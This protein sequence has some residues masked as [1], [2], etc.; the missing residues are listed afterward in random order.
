[1]RRIAEAL[2]S[3]IVGAVGLEGLLVSGGLAGLTVVAWSAD[4]RYGVLVA[5]AA[6]LAIG[7]IHRQ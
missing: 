5:S 1:M 6:A 4:W 3:L 2:H 7:A